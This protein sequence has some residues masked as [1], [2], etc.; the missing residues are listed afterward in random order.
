MIDNI[1]DRLGIGDEEESIIEDD[2]DQFHSL[3]IE[4]DPTFQSDFIKAVLYEDGTTKLSSITNTTGNLTKFEIL[5]IDAEA[6]LL[7]YIAMNR[8]P[9]L[10][11]DDDTIYNTIAESITR[12]ISLSKNKD[13]F[14]TKYL[15]G[16]EQRTLVGK[17]KNQNK[18]KEGE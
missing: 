11:R 15:L 9:S 10:V 5:I 18:K 6:E 8:Y 1:K 4:D 13:G 16:K 3:H 2:L 14:L 7:N 12:K 17:L